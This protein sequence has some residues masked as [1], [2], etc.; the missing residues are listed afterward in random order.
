MKDVKLLKKFGSNSEYS[1][2][3]GKIFMEMVKPG[4]EDE[5]KSIK[6]KL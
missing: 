3:I 5:S 1:V 4:K 2:E 6:P